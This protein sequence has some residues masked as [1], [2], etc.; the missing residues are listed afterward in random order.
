[1]LVI[2]E[3]CDGSGK[4]TLADM[5]LRELDDAVLLHRGPLERHPLEEYEADLDG[6]R[7]GGEGPH[8]ICDRWHLGELVYGPIF[9]GESKL[10]PAMR[11]HVDAYLRSRGAMLVYTAQSANV[12]KTRLR[13]RGDDMVAD[14]HVE[15]IIAGYETVLAGSLLTAWT[16]TDP[17]HTDILE[18]IGIADRLEEAAAPLARFPTY[19]GPACPS[20]LLLGE[21]RGPHPEQERMRACF[22]PYP[23][24]SGHY[25]ITGLLDMFVSDGIGLANA[26]EED[27]PALWEQLGRPRV[28]ALGNE[29]HEATPVQ[30]GVVPHPQYVRRFHHGRRDE[31]IKTIMRAAEFGSDLRKEFGGG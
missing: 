11:W 20:T 12:I 8:I 3:G 23:S 31:Y 19:V 6:Y 16:L 15:R 14:E 10:D 18:C 9:R 17:R 27:V 22:V 29:A 30:H 7:P 2:I 21:R 13:E 5:L 26:C 1:M 24:T 28:V 25:L 4:S